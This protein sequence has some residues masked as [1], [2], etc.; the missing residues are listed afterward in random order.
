MFAYID[1]VSERVDA[2]AVATQKYIELCL[3]GIEG[4]N[5]LRR[6]GYPTMVLRPGEISDRIDGEDV[7]FVPMVEVKGDIISRMSYPDSESTL[8]AENWSE[9]VSRLQDGTNNRYS[10]MYWDARKSTYDHPA[11]K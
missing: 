11:N 10:R 8:N 6:T 3:N 5:E 1:K 9:A 4:W 7:R 2:E